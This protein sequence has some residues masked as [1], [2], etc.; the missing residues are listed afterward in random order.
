MTFALLSMVFLKNISLFC[1]RSLIIYVLL[2]GVN[3]N[4]KICIVKQ[5]VL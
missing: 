5:K 3:M 2:I 4:L 1:V